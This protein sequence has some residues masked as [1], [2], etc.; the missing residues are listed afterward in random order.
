MREYG[1]I[2]CSFWTDPEI[3]SLTDQARQ[4]AAY[5][6]TGPHS[7]GLGCYRLPNGYVEAD[8][9][10]DNETVSKGFDE[11]LKIGFAK[12]CESTFF[13]FIPKFLSWNEISNPN[14][15]KSREKEFNL[16]SGKASIYAE[17]CLSLLKYGNHFSEPFRNRLET[18]SKQ[19][20]NLPRKEPTKTQPIMSAQAVVIPFAEF[21]KKYPRKT[22][23]GKAESAWKKLK[24]DKKLFDLIAKN[25]Q[26]R[27]ATNDWSLDRKEMIPHASTYLNGARWEDEVIPRGKNETSKQLSAVEQVRQATGQTGAGEIEQNGDGSVVA[28]YG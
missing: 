7:N 11:L 5:L 6:L 15:A 19:E 4:L 8:F 20:K 12:R 16:V 13:V 18:L 22:N 1:Q 28:S 21:W 17:L 23:R 26:T 2:Q 9:N 14:V 27:L 3:Q 25:I 10:W 24:P